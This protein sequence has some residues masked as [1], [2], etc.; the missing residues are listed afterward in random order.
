MARNLF[1][2]LQSYGSVAPSEFTSE[3]QLKSYDGS[4]DQNGESEP[5]TLDSTGFATVNAYPPA[6]NV[7]PTAFAAFSEPDPN[8]T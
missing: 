8:P 6:A 2:V 5:I 1:L 7:N 4:K 3:A